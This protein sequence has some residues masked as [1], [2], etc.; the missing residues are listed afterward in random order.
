MVSK[1]KTMAGMR[2]TWLLTLYAEGKPPGQQDDVHKY[3][4]RMWET[5]KDV[6]LEILSKSKLLDS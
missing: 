4:E 6:A 3:L 2:Y 5:V 1:I